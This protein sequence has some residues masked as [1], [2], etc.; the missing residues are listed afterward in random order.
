MDLLPLITVAGVA[1][2]PLMIL[3]HA[4]EGLV[5]S[6]AWQQDGRQAAGCDRSG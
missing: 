5:R 6:I 1:A 4:G 2:V 3:T